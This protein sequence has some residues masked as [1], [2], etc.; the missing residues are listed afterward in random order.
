[1]CI[2]D[3]FRRHHRAQR[4]KWRRTTRTK[5]PGVEFEVVCGTAQFK[6]R[7]PEAISHCS[8]NWLL[9]PQEQRIARIA[10]WRIA[11]WSLRAGD[12][13]TSDPP[14]RPALVDGFGICARSAAGRTS[15][16]RIADWGGLQH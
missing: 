10:D 1:M 6:F 5:T 2:R 15:A 8:I 4:A 13:A 3:R 11:D 16:R 9:A 7:M 12:F 14:S